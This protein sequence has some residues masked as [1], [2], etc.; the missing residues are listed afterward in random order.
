A[1]MQKQQNRTRQRALVVGISN[2]PA[3]ISTLPAVSADVGEIAKLLGSKN[4]TFSKQNVNLLR[5]RD[6]T[7]TKIIIALKQTLIGAQVND[8]VFVYLSGHG[9]IDN[10][11]YFFVP[12]DTN[13]RALASTG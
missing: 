7:R 1:R 8:T 13:P 4:G 2:Y 5:E 3:P 9:G 10:G 11:E 12:Y 6:A